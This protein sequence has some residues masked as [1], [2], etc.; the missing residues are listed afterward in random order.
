MIHP[1]LPGMCTRVGARA[2]QCLP[3]LVTTGLLRGQPQV[4]PRHT[5]EPSSPA[6]PLLGSYQRGV[7]GKSQTAA[8]GQE[9]KTVEDLEVE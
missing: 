6:I 4:P 7:W 3:S 1:R 5:T 2:V 9:M 8:G